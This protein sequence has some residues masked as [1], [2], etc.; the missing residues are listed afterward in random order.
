MHY[1]IV[2]GASKGIGKAIA[3]ELA[4]R[5]HALLL[6]ARSQELLEDVSEKIREQHGVDVITF[7]LDLS[8]EQAPQ[9][10][11]GLCRSRSIEADVLVNNAGYGL[12]GAFDSLSLEEQVNMMRLNME[13]VVKLTHLF[14]PEMKKTEKAYILNVASTAGYQA[15]PNLAVYSAAKAFIINFTRGL[16]HELSR[17][18]V[19]VSCLSPGTTATEF[20][21]RARMNDR[22][23]K[24]ADR[25]A[26]TPEAVAR[27]AVNG[28]FRGRMEII[29]GASNLLSAKLAAIAPK[30]L[31]ESIT[32]AIYKMQ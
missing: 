8:E 25:V 31:V 26:M 7:P 15:V 17:T 13:S 1:A 30:R 18:S 27:I 6:T 24:M 2:T 3:F 29:P 32:A 10:L 14:I 22:I 19:S 23:R 21:D 5:H 28:M 20:V 16:H 4:R 9:K 12:W 11:F